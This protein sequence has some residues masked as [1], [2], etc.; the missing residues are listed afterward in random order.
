MSRDLDNEFIRV[1]NWHDIDLLLNI[2]FDRSDVN[3]E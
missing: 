2:I 3:N 1:D